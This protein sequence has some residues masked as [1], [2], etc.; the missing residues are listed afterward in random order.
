MTLITD[1]TNLSVKLGY[2]RYISY[3]LTDISSTFNGFQC[4]FS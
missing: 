3:V 1:L 4:T 2:R